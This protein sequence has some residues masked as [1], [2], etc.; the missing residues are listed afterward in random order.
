MKAERRHE[1]QENSLIRGVRTFPEFW[2]QY[3]SKIA[4]GAI[5]VLLT[6]AL[7]R[8]WLSNR[9]SAKRGVAEQLTSARAILESFR[10]G[11]SDP[12]PEG[13][14]KVWSDVDLA[15]AEVLKNSSEPAQLAQATLLRGDLNLHWALLAAMGD[16][17][18]IAKQ[19]TLAIAGK[20]NAYLDEAAKSYNDVVNQKASLPAQP[21]F[22][23]KIGLA[24]VAENRRNFAEARSLYEAI[25][26]ES[27]D[28]FV[29]EIAKAQL[30]KLVMLESNPYIG[31]PQAAT[32][33]STTSST[34]SSTTTTSPTSTTSPATLP[35]AVIL[36]TVATLPTSTT[37]PALSMT[38]PM[39]Q[40]STQP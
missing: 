32:K 4:L 40:P 33:P 31:P 7:V 38:R 13:Q 10:R 12:T 16:P 26:K 25:Q 6:F 36:P 23:A 11:E 24:A 5:L 35:F 14:S 2:R 19:P 18:E 8:M 28:P 21:V 3:G 30:D 29:K 34:T 17:P 39:T 15:I 1:L 22:A 27:D 20:L 9:E 37:Q